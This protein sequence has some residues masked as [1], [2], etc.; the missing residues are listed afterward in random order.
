MNN[1]E[2]GWNL[3]EELDMCKRWS[4]MGVLW[5]ARHACHLVGCA[6]GGVHMLILFLPLQPAS[7]A[8]RGP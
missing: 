4:I 6:R 3:E 5:G 7:A 8:A 2:Q 1:L